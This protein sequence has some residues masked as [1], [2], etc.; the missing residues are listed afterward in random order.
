MNG[1]LQRMALNLLDLSTSLNGFEW[2]KYFK[3]TIVAHLKQNKMDSVDE[4]KN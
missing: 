1:V 4:K 3:S 2:V